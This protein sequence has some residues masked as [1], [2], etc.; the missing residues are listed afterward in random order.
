MRVIRTAAAE[1]APTVRRLR[2]RP[3]R[4]P[5]AVHALTVSNTAYHLGPT[6]NNRPIRPVRRRARP[7]RYTTCTN[8]RRSDRSDRRIRRH[9]RGS[10]PPSATSG[11]A[12]QCAGRMEL[13]R[14][15]ANAS[16]LDERADCACQV[17]DI[18]PKSDERKIGFPKIQSSAR[19]AY[20]EW[21]SS[22]T[23]SFRSS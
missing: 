2:V 3:F 17:S 21:V 20:W 9:A 10:A 5:C 13:R 1:H 4:E 12:A 18:S 11:I 14:A 7:S 19:T 22:T 16:P 8:W 15:R 6:A 23:H